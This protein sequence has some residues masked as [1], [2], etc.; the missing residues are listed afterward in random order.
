[1][2]KSRNNNK[3]I[4]ING[5]ESSLEKVECAGKILFKNISIFLKFLLE[6]CRG[7]LYLLN[8]RP[9][10]NMEQIPG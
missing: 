10:A 7:S 6:I 9:G 4:K 5:V 2:K 8:L 1:M 3:N